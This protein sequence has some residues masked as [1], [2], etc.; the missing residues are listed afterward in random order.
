MPTSGA[1]GI[2]TAGRVSGAGALRLHRLLLARR[3]QGPTADSDVHPDAA[4][5]SSNATSKFAWMSTDPRRARASRTTCAARRTARTSS[6]A[7]AAHLRRRH[8]ERR[9]APVLGRRRRRRG[10]QVA[11]D[12]VQVESREGLPAEFAIGGSVSGLV[13]ASGNRRSRPD[14]RTRMPRRSPSRP[15][16]TVSGVAGS[17]SA[18]ARTSRRSRRWFPSSCRPTSSGHSVPLP[19]QP[20]I[21]LK[22][23]RHE[24]GILQE[25][26]RRP[27]LPR[28][29]ERTMR[30]SRPTGS[31]GSTAAAGRSRSASRCPRSRSSP[32]SRPLRT[33]R[34]RGRGT[35]VRAS[36]RSIPRRSPRTRRTGTLVALAWDAVVPPDPD[37]VEYYVLRDD[38]PAGGSLRVGGVSDP[39]PDVHRHGSGELHAHVLLVRDRG[40]LA[41]M[42]VRRA[43]PSTC[44]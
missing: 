35:P 19:N 4:G 44:T 32:G 11:R 27:V 1:A 12:E 21:R 26:D 15:D 33:G 18:A 29:R 41:V 16:L 22:N 10:E 9:A 30:R 14:H 43:T 5:P 36:A 39:V 3:R 24:P 34:R 7:P 25:P 20:R 13:S 40:G 28:K 2:V 37:T 17:S 31:R 42:D 6:A 8:D 38:A 23:L